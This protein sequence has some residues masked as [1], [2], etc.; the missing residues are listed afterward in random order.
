MC[1]KQRTLAMNF[2]RAEIINLAES[3]FTDLSSKGEWN[4]VANP[5]DDSV[6]LGQ[7]KLV[8][9]DC[10]GTGHRVGDTGCKCSKKHSQAPEGED[11]SQPP[12]VNDKWG[13]P[14]E[15]ESKD[16]VINDRPYFWNAQH[17]R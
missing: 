10:G 6:F 8:C 5:G 3:V 11:M 15:G 16:K 12:P 14:K 17:H 9:W 7:R 2:L 1:I 13:I 4:G